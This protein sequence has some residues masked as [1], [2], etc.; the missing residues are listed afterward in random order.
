MFRGFV[1]LLLF[2]FAAIP[3]AGCRAVNNHGI[4]QG[5]PRPRIAGPIVPKVAGSPIEAPT[6]SASGVQNVSL[7]QPADQDN[8]LRLSELLELARTNNPELAAADANVQAMRGRLLQAG[9][10]PNPVVG[11][12]AE[13]VS[14]NRESGGQQGPFISQEFITANKLGYATAAASWGVQSSDWEAVGRWF[15]VATRI[16]G[17]YYELAAAQYALGV[18]TEIQKQIEKNIDTA[19]ALTQQ[20]NVLP[21]DVL[22][23]QV[24]LSQTLIRVNSA[25]QRV[26]AAKKLLAAAVGLNEW[27]AE[28]DNGVLL[29]EAPAYDDVAVLQTVLSRNSSVQAAQST[30]RQ[31]EAKLCLEKSQAIPNFEVRARPAYDF[32]DQNGMLFL[33]ASAPLPVNNRNQGSISEARAELLKATAE[34]R[35]VE[36]R[37]AEQVASALQRFET[38]RRN[39]Q[40]LE[41]QLLPQAE[42]AFEQTAALFETRGERY[43]DLLDAQ[44][45]L[46]QAKVELVEARRDLWQA[47]AEIEGLLQQE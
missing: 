23:F 39:V 28:I 45:S 31:S 46:S 13:E 44:R 16:R 35:T 1:W 18:N 29:E 19:E 4:S 22:K 3:V 21:A 12:Q 6:R 7:I 36:L 32:P 40:L 27:S 30:I 26:L 5:A 25:H 8:E 20:G 15:E 43:F 14:L 41:T 42:K 38:A 37:L 11:W 34:A 24:E 47:V 17:A 10:Y 9:L 33:E 2:S